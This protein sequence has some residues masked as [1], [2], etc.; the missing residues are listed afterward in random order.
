MKVTFAL[1]RRSLR[2]LVGIARLMVKSK[3][4][5]EW[6]QAAC[7]AYTLISSA[8]TGIMLKEW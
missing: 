5:A 2:A 4:P 8:L 7:Y 1:L 3:E 6:R